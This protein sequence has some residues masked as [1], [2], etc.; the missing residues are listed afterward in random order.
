MSGFLLDLRFALRHLAARPAFAAAAILTLILGIGANTTVFSMLNGYF[1]KPLPYPQGHELVS[2]RTRLPKLYPCCYISVSI[3]MYEAIKDDVP[4]FSS[5]G[6]SH[7]AAF[8]LQAKGHAQYVAGQRI[9]GDVFQTLGLKPVLGHVLTRA[10]NRPGHG[11]VAVISYRLWR[12]SFGGNAA[13]IGKRIKLD[14]E[15]YRIIGVMPQGF[16]YPNGHTD[17]WVPETVSAANQG[18]ANM[19]NFHANLIGRLKPGIDRQA[20]H[21]Q[22]DYLQARIMNAV[23][24][25]TRKKYRD[26]GFE[27]TGT[28]YHQVLLGN[29]GTKLLLLQVAVLLV[30]LIACVNVANLLLS[31]ALTRSHEMAMRLT[32]GATR[33]V[34]ARQ[35]LTE[36]LCLALPGG[37]GGTALGWFCLRLINGSPLNPPVSIFNIAFDWRVALFISA[38]IGVTAALVS[39]LPI[40]YLTKTDLQRLLQ[41]GGHTA[42]GG[43]GARKTSNVLVMGEIALATALLGGA[44]LLLHSTI[45]LQN[46]DPGFDAGN[47]L[48][49]RLL[50]ARQGPPD[51]AERVAFRRD[52]LRRVRAMP[53][54]EQAAMAGWTPLND[55]FGQT[56]FKLRGRES[57]SDSG[58]SVTYDAVSPQFFKTLGI[59]LLKGRG[60]NTSDTMNG[61]LVAVVDARFAKRFFAGRNPVGEEINLGGV[62]HHQWV[63]IVGVIPPI[64]LQKLDT[65]APY[66]IFINGMQLPASG[67][68]LL[69]RTTINPAMLVKPLKRL[70]AGINPSIAAY[71]GITNRYSLQ[72]LIDARLRGREAFLFVVLA[73]GIL[74]LMLAVI[75]VYGV[76]SFAVARR[77]KECGVRL[78][79]GAL[80]GDIEWM[81]VKNGLKLLGAGLA[82]GLAL[83]VIFG[84]MLSSQLFGVVPYDP[85]TLIGTALIL[86]VITVGACLLPARRAAKLD[87]AVAIHEQ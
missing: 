37:L 46:V 56:K 73:F 65:T 71:P 34:L 16:S 64:K 24:P 33:R 6:A 3:P 75:G 76:L 5:V 44:G 86:S 31:R 41:D 53:A 45:N 40:F 54:V 78:A 7:Y 66:E 32:L 18:V 59:P 84:F 22:L 11:R 36:G 51:N 57:V 74:A 19:F 49:M 70:I 68:R 15:S 58:P 83:A 25:E 60:F 81:I 55:Y 67:M 1:L 27:L 10:N 61:Q 30:L 14:G 9:I 48:N 47:V 28:P 52:V 72:N 69:V 2:V 77:V 12:S 50:R 17:V 8:N 26:Y 39:V 62:S 13:A 4:A 20:L 35:L 82:A 38:V 42:G 80:P 43:R 23:S 29:D 85:L 79:L 63:R 87:P 21:A